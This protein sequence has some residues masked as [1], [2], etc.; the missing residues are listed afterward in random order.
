MQNVITSGAT[1]A[2]HLGRKVLAILLAGLLAT[3]TAGGQQV[4]DRIVA[5]V[6]DEIILLSDLNDALQ[7]SAVQFELDPQ[8]DRDR[9]EKLRVDLLDRMID[10]K[11]LLV[12]AK[13]DSIEVKD[14]EVE[15]TLEDR[16]QQTIERHGSEDAFNDEL[17]RYGLTIKELKKRYRQEIHNELL[18]DR[19]MQS[20]ISGID[21]SRREVEEFYETYKDSLPAQEEA[22][23]IAHL[24]LEVKPGEEEKREARDRIQRVLEEVRTGADFAEL[25]K[26]YSEGPSAPL[27]G[28]LGFF[29][30]GTMVPDFEQAAFALDVGGISDIV[31]TQ[32]GYHIIKCEEKRG[33][34]V[35]VR[36]ILVQTTTGPQD[37]ERTKQEIATLRKRIDEGEDF[38]TLVREYSHDPTTA[39][40]GG[41]LGW[42]YVAQIPPHF[43]TEIESLD[44]GGVSAPIETEFGYHLIKV[45]E[46][47]ENRAL[48]LEEDWDTIKGMATQYKARDLY[49]SWLRDL[50][51]KMYVDIRLED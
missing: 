41:E 38:S 25:A 39:P 45:L 21:I 18:A 1:P 20:K 50:R 5:V 35:R 12:K 46:R 29:A 16:I 9:I 8:R 7:Q 14:S 31:E 40:T 51:E 30:P 27:G 13:E 22:V 44:V 15:R 43:K 26:K 4:I 11:V 49:T 28:D 34:E 42:F 2:A 36:H 47:R 3:G 37:E 33:D 19:V 23:R 32:F 10:E 48:T 17:Q 24:L 6:D